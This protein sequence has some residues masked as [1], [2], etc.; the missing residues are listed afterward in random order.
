MGHG[1]EYDVKRHG[2]CEYHR[3]KAHHQ[4][5]CK[6][7]QSFFNKPND[8]QADKVWAAEV[9]GIY[10]AVRHTHSCRSTAVTS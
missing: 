1:G 10:H 3:K 6:S 9:T 4:E 5:T 2:A 7:V 8:P